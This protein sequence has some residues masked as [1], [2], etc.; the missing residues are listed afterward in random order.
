TYSFTTTAADSGEEFEA[1]FWNNVSA[2][3]SS[4]AT[5]TI[6]IPPQVT[7]QPS[8]VTTAAG[9]SASI[10]AAASGTPAPSVQ[11][12]V[13]TDGGNTWGTVAGATSTTYFFTTSWQESGYQYRAVFTNAVGSVSSAA[14]TLTLTDQTSSNWSG[15]VATGGTF[16]AV[17]ASWTV[18]AVTCNSTSPSYSADWVGIDGE[19]SATVEQDGTESDCLG[20]SPSYDAWYELYGDNAFHSGDEV[21][22]SKSAYPVKPGDS[23]TAAV[24]VISG[25]WTL[26]VSNATESWSSVTRVS[27]STPAQSSAEWVAERPT[28]GM[29][30]PSLA[31]FGT[32]AFTGAAATDASASGPISDFIFAPIEMLASPSDVLASPGQL[33]Q[34]GADF[35]ATWN[36]SS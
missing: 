22:L 25:A 3:T 7:T 16:S 17:T 12:Q 15:Y 9:S 26:T 21:E 36:S 34:T 10:T 29:S 13:S 32:V 23:I 19:S 8:S 27:W 35:T 11:W 14:A 2:A 31:N 28:I 1:V 5:L 20:G 6:G 18:P 30:L 33:D 4:P 24:S